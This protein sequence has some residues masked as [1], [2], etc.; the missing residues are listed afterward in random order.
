VADR[1][2]SFAFGAVILLL[3]FLAMSGV[4]SASVITVDT[5]SGVPAPGFCSLPDAIAAH[6]SPRAPFNACALGSGND[7]I[8][9]TVTGTITIGETLAVTSGVLFLEGPISGRPAGPPPAAGVAISGGGTV[10]IFITS[11]G[12]T[13]TL[14]NLTLTDGLAPAGSIGGGAIFADGTDLEVAGLDTAALGL[15]GSNPFALMLTDSDL[16]GFGC[17]TITNAIVGNQIPTPRKVRRGV[18]R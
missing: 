5:L 2:R 4:A 7:I 17:F 15:G 16:H 10:Q 13:V 6:N 9:F 11:P 8:D 12:T 3:L 18:R 1:I 14:A